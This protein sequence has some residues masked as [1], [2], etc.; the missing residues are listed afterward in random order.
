MTLLSGLY[1]AF[2]I[3][4]VSAAKVL[5]AGGMQPGGTL[6]GGS[7]SLKKLLLVVQLSVSLLMMV[8]IAVVYRSCG[9]WISSVWGSTRRGC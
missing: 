8:G 4:S 5:K 2:F 9:L 3:S 7:I 1:P 6:P